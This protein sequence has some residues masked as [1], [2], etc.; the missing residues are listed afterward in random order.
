M[1]AEFYNSCN[2][3]LIIVIHHRPFFSCVKQ[4][5]YQVV[6]ARKMYRLCKCKKVLLSWAHCVKGGTVA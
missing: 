1:A 6:H 3:A 2:V 4:I 5:M